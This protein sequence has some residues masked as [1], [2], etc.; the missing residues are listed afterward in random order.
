MLGAPDQKPNS[1]VKSPTKEVKKDQPEQKP[2]QGVLFGKPNSSTMPNV[3]GL[4]I[5]SKNADGIKAQPEKKEDAKETKP[6]VPSG[7]FGGPSQ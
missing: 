3:N 1:K 5:P 6:P 2:A 7:M 4:L